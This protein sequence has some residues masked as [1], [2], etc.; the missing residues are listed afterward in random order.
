MDLEISRTVLWAV[1]GVAFVIIELLT[2]HFILLFFGVAALMTALTR[3]VGL[4][5][6]PGEVAL[7][8]A[9]GVAGLIFFRKRLSAAYAH[10]DQYRG[11]RA[12][13]FVLPCDAPPGIEVQVEYQGAPWRAMNETSFSLPK[14]TKVYIRRVEGVRLYIGPN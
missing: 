7:F 10:R 12:E 6:L 9:L 11:D 5:H 14:G 4:N 8:A 13:T 3:L 1:L 2:V